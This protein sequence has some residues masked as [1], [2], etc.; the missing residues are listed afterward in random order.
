M[1][2][3]H[4]DMAVHIAS[5]L[6]QERIA[7]SEHARLIAA[8]RSN[9]PGQVSMSG[10]RRLTGRTLIRVGAWLLEAPASPTYRPA[11]S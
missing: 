11:H 2:L 4:P 10:A 5:D 8:L 3:N 9:A 6:H 7:A 1:M